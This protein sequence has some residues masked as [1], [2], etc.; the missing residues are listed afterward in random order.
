[1]GVL[2]LSTIW[3]YYFNCLM[4]LS[5]FKMHST[6]ALAKVD[7]QEDVIQF[8]EN[9]DK[10]FVSVNGTVETTKL[11][12][13]SVISNSI[14]TDAITVNN[15]LESLDSNKFSVKKYLCLV[16]VILFVIGIAQIPIILYYTISPDEGVFFDDADFQSCSVSTFISL[17]AFI[18]II[19]LNFCIFNEGTP[20]FG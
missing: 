14:A 20:H 5:N 16:F 10:V 12:A 15:T 19:I 4:E 17:F 7:S 2:L 3:D 18:I 1:M 9:S 8:N 13:T 6:D 11:G